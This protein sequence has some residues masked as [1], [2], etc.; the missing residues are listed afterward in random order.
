MTPVDAIGAR[1][2]AGRDLARTERA[3]VF[4]EG[5]EFYF[6]IAQHVRIRRAAGAVFRQ[7]MLEHPV[8]VFGSKIAR[9]KRDAEHGADA[10]RVG[11]VAFRVTLAETFVFF[12]ILHEHAAE[13]HALTLQ[14]QRRDAGIDAAGHA[15][16]DVGHAAHASAG[17]GTRLSRGCRLPARKSS[18]PRNT[19]GLRRRVRSAAISSRVSHTARTMPASR[20]RRGSCATGAAANVKRRKWLSVAALLHW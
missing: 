4:E 7:E 12:P 18:T 16:D 1:V 2:V 19:I 17:S 9:V 6:T 5:L 20:F 14:Q 8:P 11:A 10:Q 15:D 3:R 13:R